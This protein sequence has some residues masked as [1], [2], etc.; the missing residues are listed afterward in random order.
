MSRN[1]VVTEST[2]ND[3][4]P[5][6]ELNSQ[7]C[8][9]PEPV[10]IDI[11]KDLSAKTILKCAECWL[12]EYKRLIDN[13]PLVLTDDIQDA[14]THQVLHV[15]FSHN[16]EMF[17][18][19]SKDGYVIVRESKLRCRINNRPYDIFGAWLTDEFVI[20]GNLHW[21]AQL[22]TT[23]VLWLN[24]ANQEIY[25]EHVPVTNQLYKFY[26]RNASS[27][28]AIIVANCPWLDDVKTCY[29]NYEESRPEYLDTGASD[30]T[31]DDLE[32]MGP[33]YL[34]FSTGSSTYTPHQVGFKFVHHVNFPRTLERGPSLKERIAIK[35]QERLLQNSEP[36]VEPNWLDYEAVA[37]H[38]DPVD[39]IIDL[40]GHI[41]GMGLSPDH[42]YLYVHCGEWLPNY[43]I[44]NP[45]EPPPIAQ[46]INIHVI[47]LTT[48]TKV[49]QTF[50]SHTNY[51]LNDG[52]HY[53]FMDVCDNYLASGAEDMQAYV[54]DRHYGICLAKNRHKDVVNSVAFN[55]VDSEMLVTTSD[56]STIKV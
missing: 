46:E 26:N 33:K 25:S 48:L 34:I 20:S 45:L 41:I 13:V 10:F 16:G 19:C 56:D 3:Q 38:F 47:D 8:M 32:N 7:W 2:T 23:S 17:A 54:W 37:D 28:R 53:I 5:Y 31:I 36:R 51:T 12:S 4:T 50:Q 24:K 21:L 9:I 44:S 15:S 40:H 29:D 55:P 52:C 18:T 35:K 43:I 39:V 14:H 42:R 11:L 6:E 22:V 27:I 49:D 1:I 30:T